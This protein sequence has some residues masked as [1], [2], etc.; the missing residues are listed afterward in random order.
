MLS[1][2]CL[3]RV[4]GDRVAILCCESSL[5]L[6]HT[7]QAALHCPDIPAPGR[8][9]VLEE[10]PVTYLSVQHLGSWENPVP[11]PSVHWLRMRGCMR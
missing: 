2:C 4:T 3:H 8:A 1:V 10:A 11:R 9:I 5:W 7:S 6:L